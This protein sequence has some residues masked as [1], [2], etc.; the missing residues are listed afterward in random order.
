M[1][2]PN[3]QRCVRCD[4]EV[5]VQFQYSRRLRRGMKAYLF[6]PIA[7]LPVYPF[8]AS[9]YVVSLPLMMLYMLGIGPALTIIRDPPTC[10]TCG[11]FIPKT[12]SPS[13]APAP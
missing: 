6:I 11:A 13:P 1:S 9:D 3:R 10:S 7:L 8:A 5:E 2:K 12:S 4:R